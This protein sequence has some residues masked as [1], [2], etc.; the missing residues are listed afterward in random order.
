MFWDGRVSAAAGYFDSPAGSRL[1]DGLDS[2]LA[3]QAM[4]PPTSRHEMR[5]EHG[6]NE[7]GDVED[8]Q[9]V[10]I[11]AGITERL[12][13]IDEYVIMFEEAYPDVA[14]DDVGFEHAANALAAFEVA[15]FT[16]LDSPFDRFLAGDDEALSDTEKYGASLFFGSHGCV[17]CHSGPLFTD[18]ESHAIA[19]P[20]LGPGKLDEE[21][22]LDLGRMLE[23]DDAN[24]RFA[25]RTPPLRNVEL[26]GPY[27]H[28]G[29]YATL[30]DAIRH[31]V[32][33][34]ESLKEYG[35][36]HLTGAHQNSV[37]VDSDTHEDMIAAIDPEL[38]GCYD[39]TEDDVVAL[40]QFLRS[41]TDPSARTMHNLVPTSV[42]SGLPVE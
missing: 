23:T 11:W 19:S 39:L 18:Q 7:L 34:A 1:P 35:G 2:V 10:D 38:A 30:E 37:V 17:G 14:T 33:P 6:E 31:H 26:T 24:D 22:R 29:A 28:A 5:G 13:G 4:F 27:M 12:M 8:S 32:R 9:L 21:G 40:A 36:S 41:L 25:F 15:A 20:Q 42:P 3:V 16:K